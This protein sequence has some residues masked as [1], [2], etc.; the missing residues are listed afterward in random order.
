MKKFGKKAD[1]MKMRYITTEEY[2]V[3]MLNLDMFCASPYR[4]AISLSMYAAI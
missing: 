4:G 3:K 1:S 2:P